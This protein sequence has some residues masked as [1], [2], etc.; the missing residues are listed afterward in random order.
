MKLFISGS[1][2]SSSS[3]PLWKS[4]MKNCPHCDAKLDQDDI[5]NDECP[6]CDEKLNYGPNDN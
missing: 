6:Y 4:V 3:E 1:D 2:S 5:D